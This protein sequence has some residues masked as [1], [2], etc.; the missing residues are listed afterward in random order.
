MPTAEFIGLYGVTMPFAAE[1]A[2]LAMLLFCIPQKITLT[3]ALLYRISGQWISR[4]YDLPS[5]KIC[6]DWTV[7]TVCG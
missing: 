7:A 1:C 6:F 2:Q 3:E 5:F 4:G